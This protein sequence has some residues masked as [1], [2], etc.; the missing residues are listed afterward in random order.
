MA[1][2]CRCGHN[3]GGHS[4]R[5]GLRSPQDGCTSVRRRDICSRWPWPYRYDLANSRSV[6]SPRILSTPILIPGLDHETCRTPH[7]PVSFGVWCP[8][9]RR[10]RVRH[11][12]STGWPL[13]TIGGAATS[14]NRAPTHITIQVHL[15]SVLQR[16]RCDGCRPSTGRQSRNGSTERI[17][18]VRRVPPVVLDERLWLRSNVRFYGRQPMRS[19]EHDPR[20]YQ[21]LHRRPRGLVGSTLWRHSHV[22]VS[23]T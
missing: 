17:V 7:P 10:P 9:P 19:K 14:D 2:L 5:S 12:R 15:R 23:A 16:G 20:R 8:I 4:G 21:N 1:G 22:S 6:A 3:S 18:P 13:S 11:W